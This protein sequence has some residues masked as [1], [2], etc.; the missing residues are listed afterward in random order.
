MKPTDLDR[1]LDRLRQ[2]Y[3]KR[4][5]IKRIV[6]TRETPLSAKPRLPYKDDDSRHVWKDGDP[7]G[8]L[9]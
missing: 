1:A 4:K 5:R 8:P 3:A 7:L 9:D 6:K 2:A